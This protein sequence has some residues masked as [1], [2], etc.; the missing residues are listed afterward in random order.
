M[1]LTVTELLNTNVAV[2]LVGTWADASGNA[3][4]FGA[5]SSPTL[6][7]SSTLGST[8]TINWTGRALYLLCQTHTSYGP[9][10]VT[11]DGQSV[12]GDFHCSNAATNPNIGSTSGYFNRVLVPIHRGVADTSHTTVLTVAKNSYHSVVGGIIGVSVD[13]F[14]SISGN[15]A[16]PTNGLYVALGDS[17]GTG[18]GAFNIYDNVY[19]YIVARQL[20]QQLN[21]SITLINACVSGNCMFGITGAGN[22]GG[23]YR[24]FGTDGFFTGVTN[25]PPEYLSILYGANDLRA[26]SSGGQYIG[27]QASAADYERHLNNMMCFLEDTMDVYGTYGTP[28]KVISCSPPHLPANM[29]HRS[30]QSFSASNPV[31]YIGGGLT[32]FITAAKNTKSVVA[33]FR[34]GRYCGIYEAMGFRDELLLPNNNTGQTIVGYNNVTYTGDTGLHPHDMTH[35][36]LASEITQTA[37]NNSSN[38]PLNFPPTQVLGVG[39]I[40]GGF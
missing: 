5:P 16:S 13:S 34:W 12:L 15:Q 24:L 8:V 33:R 10:T 2:S 6:K 36:F 4:T 27:L 19:P 38:T 31:R 25:N 40:R 29:T 7:V 39:S 18:G 14:V 22:V 28:V 35:G 26:E 20:Q 37:L 3:S 23:M 17:W 32:N 9:F 1:A 21:K 30:L 11:L